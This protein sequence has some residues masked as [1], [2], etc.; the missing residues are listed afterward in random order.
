MLVLVA[1]SCLNLCN[2]SSPPTSSVHGILQARVL[3]WA[4]TSLS[5]GSSQPRDQTQAPRIPGKR[6]N[7]RATSR[8]LL[9]I[10]FYIVIV[11]SFSHVRLFATPWTA[12]YQASC[13]SL[14]P[15]V[16]SNSY[17][18]SCSDGKESVCNAGDLGLIPGLGRSPGEGN[19]YLLQYS[20]LE[21][22]MEA[23]AW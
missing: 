10:F 3:E 1:Q 4:A 7:L 12:A 21:N 17:P 2:Q 22:P 8:S 14:S 13:P 23:G 6:P 19:G 15:R 18:L 16:C 11:Q 20:Y 9:I 5:M